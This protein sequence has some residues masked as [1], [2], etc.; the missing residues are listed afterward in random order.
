MIKPVNF[1]ENVEYILHEDRKS[2]KPTKW[3]FRPLELQEEIYLRKIAAKAVNSKD[4]GDAL[5]VQPVFL[6]VALC[7][8]ENWDGEFKR[9][10]KAEPIVGDIKPWT[11]RTLANIPRDCRQELVNFAMRGYSELSEDELKN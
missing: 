4:I 2:K 8:A 5:D 11:D 1:E 9:N 3:F 6:H 7:G 10:E